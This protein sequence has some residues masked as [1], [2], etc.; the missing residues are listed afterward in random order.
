MLSL[1]TELYSTS[2]DST[3]TALDR[4]DLPVWLPGQ[5]ISDL[6]MDNLSLQPCGAKSMPASRR[7][8]TSSHDE[9]LVEALS[10]DGTLWGKDRTGPTPSPGPVTQSMMVS[11]RCNKD[12]HARP[13]KQYNVGMML[14]EQLDQEMHNVLR[15]LPTSDDDK[16]ASYANKVSDKPN[17]TLT[18]SMDLVGGNLLARLPGRQHPPRWTALAITLGSSGPPSSRRGSPLDNLSNAMRSVPATPL[19]MANGSSNHL[20]PTPGTPLTPDGQ[21]LSGSFIQYSVDS[22][23]LATV[24]YKFDAAGWERLLWPMGRVARPHFTTTMG[25]VMVL[26]LDGVAHPTST[27]LPGTR[28]EDLQGEIPALARINMAAGT[29]K[30]ARGRCSEHRDMIFRETFGHFADLMT[31]PQWE[32]C[33]PEMSHKVAHLK[34]TRT[35]TENYVVQYI[36]DLN[37]NRFSDGVIRQFAGNV[38]AL[39]VQKF[40]SN[41]IEKCSAWL[42]IALEKCS[43]KNCLIGSHL[44]K[45]LR[46]SYGNYCVQ[47]DC[48]DYVEP[49][50]RA[51]LV[52]GI[53]PVLPLIRNTPYGKRIQNKLPRWIPWEIKWTF[54]AI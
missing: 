48:T 31:G 50:Q 16:F 28:I 19:S 4:G 52:E 23:V 21:N 42:N 8:F 5:D 43:S 10:R 12:D 2:C 20:L 53:R 47:V 36:L 44:E 35:H 7:T 3:V 1:A 22:M 27:G 39:S 37:D 17:M 26:V 15:N 40:S 14:D 9:E 33:H 49:T 24:L 11:G 30:E 18:S 41:V 46:D 38:C 29:F 25:P 34:T 51:L 54:Y 6:Q 45:L 32:P 13:G